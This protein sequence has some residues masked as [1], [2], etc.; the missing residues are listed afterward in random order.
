MTSH[1]WQFWWL[2]FSTSCLHLFKTW[3][4]Q[5][6]WTIQVLARGYHRK[7]DAC[8]SDEKWFNT[9]Y[10]YIVLKI[11]KTTEV[12]LA[13]HKIFDE[14]QEAKDWAL[15]SSSSR[16]TLHIPSISDFEEEVKAEDCRQPWLGCLPRSLWKLAE[17][18]A[19]V[20]N[21]MSQLLSK[22]CQL[23]KKPFLNLYNKLLYK[24]GLLWRGLW[25][26]PTWW[27][28]CSHIL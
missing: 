17:L 27:C 6:P 13:G 21:P 24:K 18:G 14:Y 22:I 12:K 23:K 25:F 9:N 19:T 7:R 1:T 28:S 5:W 16:W 26:K 11:W 20:S 15:T 10:H 3:L 8:P 4:M 2:F